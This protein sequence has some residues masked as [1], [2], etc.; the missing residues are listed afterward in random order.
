M[1][2]S[3]NNQSQLNQK[4]GVVMPSKSSVERKNECYTLGTSPGSSGINVVG[5]SSINVAN[6]NATIKSENTIEGNLNN[7]YT[8]TNVQGKLKKREKN[9]RVIGENGDWVMIEE[10]GD[11]ENIGGKPK[12]KN[13][14]PQFPT[15]SDKIG[16]NGV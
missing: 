4:L 9:P 6:T 7:T 3:Y 2:A 12:R 1:A 13:V 10:Y 8:I 14:I 11:D 5:G 16:G 15:V